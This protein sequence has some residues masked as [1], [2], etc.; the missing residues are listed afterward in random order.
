MKHKYNGQYVTRAWL[1]FYELFVH[2]DLINV[3]S[4]R[5]EADDSAN[6]AKKLKIFF[7]AE[8]PGAGISAVNHLVKTYYSGLDYSWVASSL[9]IGEDTE[10]RINA[11]G[12]QYGIWKHNPDSWLMDVVVPDDTVLKNTDDNSAQ[13]GGFMNNGDVTVL[14]NIIDMV[15][16]VKDSRPNIYTHD[17]GIDVSEA[18]NELGEQTGFNTQEYKNMKIHFGCAL[19]A[20]ET[21]AEGGCFIGKQ[22]TFFETFTIN[23]ILI[24]ASMFE[25]FYICKP[26]TSGHSNSEIYLVGIGFKGFS[27]KYRDVLR[28][29][30]K[31]WNTDPFIPREELEKQSIAPALAEIFRYARLRNTEQ[32]K[33]INE[34]LELFNKFKNRINDL[35]RYMNGVMRNFAEDWVRQ[36]NPKRIARDDWI[37]SNADK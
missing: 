1:K 14:E 15:E 17:A 23:L 27:A 10:D 37:P 30:M 18:V 25:Q 26:L 3:S 20:L 2:F 35:N 13:K 34:N 16:K 32:I 9:V 29:R 7:N 4:E 11:L 31:N 5:E 21:L 12:D 8:L 19:T 24:Y 28:H 36:M 33:Y 6:S 22:Y